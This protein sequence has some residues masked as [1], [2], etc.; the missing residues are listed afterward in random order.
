MFYWIG[1]DMES[2]VRVCAALNF[3]SDP[4]PK[5]NSWKPRGSTCAPVHIG[6][7]AGDDDIPGQNSQT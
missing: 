7:V 6:H 2:N 1:N 4:P 3:G 5:L